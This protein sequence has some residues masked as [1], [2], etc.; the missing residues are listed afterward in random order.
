MKN[1]LITAGAAVALMAAANFEFHEP[2]PATSLR[3]RKRNR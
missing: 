3:P 1:F 2:K